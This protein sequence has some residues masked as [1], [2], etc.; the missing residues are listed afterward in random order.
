LI[1]SLNKQRINN[2]GQKVA[3]E[4]MAIALQISF[5][6]LDIWLRLFMVFLTPTV[7]NPELPYSLNLAKP[8]LSIS[9]SLCY[10]LYILSFSPTDS[11]I[12]IVSL[13]KQQYINGVFSANMLKVIKIYTIYRMIQE[14]SSL[15]WEVTISIN[16][17]CEKK[18][19][20][21]FC[22][23]LN[24]FRDIAVW[25]WRFLN[26]HTR[27]TKCIEVDGEIFELLLWTVTNLSLLC[28]KFVI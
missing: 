28:N 14:E 27:V 1:A 18:V 23:I 24:G 8:P 2:D 17:S 26:L 9:L 15:F 19:H 21:N 3:V 20:T 10:S 7:A 13:K 11:E 16:G 6:R 5:R 4:W 22:L 25:I 12:L